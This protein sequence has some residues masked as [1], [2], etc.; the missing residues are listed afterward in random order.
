MH[1]DE[2]SLVLSVGVAIFDSVSELKCRLKMYLM[3][4]QMTSEVGIHANIFN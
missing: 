1:D 3:V 4:L 2:R